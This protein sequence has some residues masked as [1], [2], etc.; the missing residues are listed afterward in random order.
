MNE[1]LGILKEF[2]ATTE[3]IESICGNSTYLAF[4]DYSGAV[5]YYKLNGEAEPK[6]KLP[7]IL[8]ALFYLRFTIMRIAC[9]M[10]K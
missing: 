9:M 8:F 6:V 3:R 5:R 10:F 2:A 1:S 4:G 7:T